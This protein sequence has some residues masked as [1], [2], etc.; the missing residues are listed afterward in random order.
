MSLENARE[1]VDFLFSKKPVVLNRL[2]CLYEEDDIGFRTMVEIIVGL[3]IEFNIFNDPW[4]PG[5]SLV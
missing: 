2:T 1:R 3:W 5:T 4:V